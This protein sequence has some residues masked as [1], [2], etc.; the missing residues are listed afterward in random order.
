MLLTTALF[1]SEH[2]IATRRKFISHTRFE[3]HMAFASQRGVVHIHNGRNGTIRRISAVDQAFTDW[4]PF[5]PSELSPR[6][7]QTKKNKLK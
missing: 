4:E 2:G 1:Q 7:R 3:Y 5:A 6:I